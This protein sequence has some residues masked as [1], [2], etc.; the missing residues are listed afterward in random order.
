[1][2]EELMTGLAIGQ[3]AL[4]VNVYYRLGKVEQKVCDIKNFLLNNRNDKL[5]KRKRL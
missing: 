4:L 3:I 5:K 1:M 2:L